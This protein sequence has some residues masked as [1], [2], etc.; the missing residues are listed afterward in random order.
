MSGNEG[1][2]DMT[3]VS[4]VDTK[5]DI[6]VQLQLCRNRMEP[7]DDVEEKEKQWN[8]SNAKDHVV[9]KQEKNHTKHPRAREKEMAARDANLSH[10]PQPVPLL[11]FGQTD[12]WVSTRKKCL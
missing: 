3:F 1:F 5:L 12:D 4:L 11:R 8:S 10:L 6:P 9:E 2:E 7:V